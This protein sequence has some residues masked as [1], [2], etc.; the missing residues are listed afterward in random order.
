MWINSRNN[1]FGPISSGW[2]LRFRKGYKSALRHFGDV[3]WPFNEWVNFDRRVF[4]DSEVPGRFGWWLDFE[5]CL[6]QEKY[7]IRGNYNNAE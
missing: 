6:V 4:A 7:F 2:Y 5:F 1:R 3:G